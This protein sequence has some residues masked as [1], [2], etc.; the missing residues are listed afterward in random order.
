MACGIGR[1]VMES[2]LEARC[3][4]PA[5]LQLVARLYSGTQIDTAFAIHEPDVRAPL[6]VVAS[7]QNRAE[8][9]AACALLDRLPFGL[10]ALDAQCLVRFEN[11]AARDAIDRADILVREDGR[12]RPWS[13]RDLP[14]FAHAAEC[15]CVASRWADEGVEIL[16][17]HRY[18]EMSLRLLGLRMGSVPGALMILLLPDVARER[19]LR[20][21]LMTLFA[22]TAAE[23]DVA[24]LMMEGLSLEEVARQRGV[25]L[26]TARG[27]WHTARYKVSNSDDGALIDL[28]RAALL[29]QP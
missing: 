1:P 7:L 18:R 12:V 22:L 14:R 6:T 20:R 8:Q 2:A 15:A 4:P 29:L 3:P 13:D 23:T 24:I 28:L 19:S 25:R 5:L 16:V 10:V 9:A 21:L 11:Q 27:Q 26:A 17:A